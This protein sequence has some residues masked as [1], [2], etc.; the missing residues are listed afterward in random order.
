MKFILIVLMLALSGCAGL[1]SMPPNGYSNTADSSSLRVFFDQYGGLFPSSPKALMPK[2]KIFGS[3]YAFSIRTHM[4]NT[5]QPYTNESTEKQYIDLTN[6]ISEKLKT[7][8]SKLVFLV[9]GYNN[10]FDQASSSFEYVKSFLKSSSKSN[11][12]FVEVYWDGL[13]KGPF[14]SPFPLAYWFDSLTYSNIAGQ[15]GLRKL[16]NRLPIET[17]LTVVTHSR[18]AGV[19]FSAISNPLY[20]DHIVVPDFEEFKG[21]N[22][23]NLNIVSI[24]PAVGNG[25]PTDD[26][27]KVLP[28]GAKIFIG[29]NESDPALQKSQGKIKVGSNKFGDTS[30]GTDNEFYLAAEKSANTARIVLQRVVYKG[31]NAH[32]IRG[33]ID[34]ESQTKC[35]FWASKLVEEKPSACSLVR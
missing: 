16:I 17:D 19:I 14:S 22:I 3:N 20:D 32:G 4:K 10:S 15:V 25:H 13:L 18:G 9:H 24:A 23:S 29:F 26:L 35:L 28:E 1:H 7:K 30:L 8:N 11:Y 6:T 2:Q 27:S 12:V 33:Y 21:S 5:E 34:A 31:Y